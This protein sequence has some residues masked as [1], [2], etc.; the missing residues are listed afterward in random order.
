MKWMMKKPLTAA[1]VLAAAGLIGCDSKAADETSEDEV[2]VL[3]VDSLKEQ[4]DRE[5][6]SEIDPDK[7][8]EEFEALRKA[9]QGDG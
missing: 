5:A 9:D 6:E 4:F 8:S 7:L 3:D 2:E 1:L